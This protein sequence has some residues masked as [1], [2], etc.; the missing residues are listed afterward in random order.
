M[1][2]S[3]TENLNFRNITGIT[4]DNHIFGSTIKIKSSGNDP[5]FV[6]GFWKSEAERIKE[7]CSKK[8]RE[9]TSH[10][11]SNPTPSSNNNL[12]IADELKKLKELIDQGV[13]NQEEFDNLK[14]KLMNS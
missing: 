7:L 10:S 11:F 14:S 5:I 1:I 12:S 13:I 8:T 2:S 6:H 4:I 3:D 9:T